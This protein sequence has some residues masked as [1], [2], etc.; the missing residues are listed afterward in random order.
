[1][2]L[3]RHLSF[4]RFHVPITVT[5]TLVS[6]HLPL[7]RLL[8]SDPH[9]FCACP[10]THAQHASYNQAEN[11]GDDESGMGVSLQTLRIAGSAARE[12]KGG[13]FGVTKGRDMRCGGHFE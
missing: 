10:D 6:F 12:N 1:M 3:G 9:A 2:V 8:L 5:S 4:L 13:E 11:Y 7:T